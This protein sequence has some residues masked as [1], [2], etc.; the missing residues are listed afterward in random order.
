MKKSLLFSGVS[1]GTA[2]GSEDDD[3][4]KTGDMKTKGGMQFHSFERLMPPNFGCF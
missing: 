3:R 4:K 1:S 2:T